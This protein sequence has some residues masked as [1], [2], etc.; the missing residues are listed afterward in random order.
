ML[1]SCCDG[2]GGNVP[3]MAA[4]GGAGVITVWNLEERRLHTIV[5]VHLPAVAVFSLL[6][7]QLLTQGSH[8]TVA[9][10]KVTPLL[11]ICRHLGL[12]VRLQS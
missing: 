5:K 4:G 3:L 2:A 7:V 9:S 8:A 10:G 6:S 1:Y 11:S 12:T